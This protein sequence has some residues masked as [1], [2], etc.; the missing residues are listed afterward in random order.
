MTD[1]SDLR[2]HIRYKVSVREL[3]ADVGDRMLAALDEGATPDYAALLEAARFLPPPQTC[4]HTAP[5]TAREAIRAAGLRPGAGENWNGNAD[6]QPLG[7]YIGA[8]PDLRGLW[9][10]TDAW[11]I[12]AIDMSELREG[13][14]P[15]SWGHDRLNPGC[16]L[17]RG[18]VPPSRLMLWRAGV[19]H[20]KEHA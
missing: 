19:T 5:I 7:V 10:H 11:D 16:W 3:Q 1:E 17:I 20:T 6:G 14:G 2:R 4:Y 13:D 12:W 18:Q 8:Q 9:A 15:D